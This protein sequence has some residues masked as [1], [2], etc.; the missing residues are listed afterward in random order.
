MTENAPAKEGNITQA[1]P[2]YSIR[3]LTSADN[4][5]L[6]DF[7]YEAI[8]VPAGV[9]A[10]PRSIIKLPELKL[11]T[12]RFGSSAHDKGFAAE[13]E[14]KPIG[15]V[16]T[17]I[18]DDYGHIDNDTPS[19]SISVYPPYR[20][21]GIGTALMNEML[22]ELKRCGYTKTSLSVQKEND[23]VRLYRKIGYK[24]LQ[25]NETDYIMLYEFE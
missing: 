20:G 6:E 19:L 11:Y 1:T 14:G 3:R 25:E 5:L 15:A 9:E 18:I 13:I 17:R 2:E 24:L 8:F 10:P 22:A 12:D 21:L 7:L 23:A 4:I 16:W